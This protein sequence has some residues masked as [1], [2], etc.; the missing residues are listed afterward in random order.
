MK[1]GKNQ[2]FRLDLIAL[3]VAIFGWCHVG[4]ADIADAAGDLSSPRSYTQGGGYGSQTSPARQNMAGSY[5]GAYDTNAS[6]TPYYRAPISG[7]YYNGSTS[8]SMRSNN[9]AGSWQGSNRPESDLNYETGPSY[10]YKSYNTNR[11]FNTSPTYEGK[12]WDSSTYSGTTV[13]PYGYNPDGQNGNNTGYVYEGVTTSGLLTE[14]QLL[15]ILSPQGKQLYLSLNPEGK[16]LALQ[17]ASQSRYIDKDL[18][19]K[20]AQQRVAESRR[21]MENR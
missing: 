16:A 17:L 14:P 21:A 12:Y 5:G 11:G 13:A 6:R 3:F 2:F 1:I 18:A 20:E 19:V 9:E 15:A 7:G 10:N 4:A 8:G